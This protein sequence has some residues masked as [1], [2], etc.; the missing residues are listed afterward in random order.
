MLVILALAEQRVDLVDEDDRGLKLPG[1]GEERPH[2]LLALAHVLG[3]QASRRYGEEGGVALGGHG[4]GQQGLAVAR[5]PEQQQSPGRGAQTREQLRPQRRQ[6]H[7]FLQGLLG[8][9]Q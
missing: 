9:L 8:R 6:Y 1:Y 7:H 4:P 3:G 5:R 2:E